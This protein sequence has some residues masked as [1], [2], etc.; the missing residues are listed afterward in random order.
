MKFGLKNTL[1]RALILSAPF[2]LISISVYFLSLW[3]LDVALEGNLYYRLATVSP[4]ITAEK[5]SSVNPYIAYTADDISKISDNNK[6][7]FGD[8]EDVPVISIGDQWATITIESADVHSQPVFHGN[9]D[10]LL[11][12]GIGHYTNSRFPGQHG[13]VILAGHVGIYNHFQRLETMQ[14]GDIVKLDTIYGSYVYRVT[15]TYIMES[16]SEEIR[17]LLL[18]DSEDTGDRLICYTCYPYR[19]TKVRTQRFIIDCELVSGYDFVTGESV[20]SS[21]EN[22]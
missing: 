16:N 17:S 2:L 15:N 9:S 3:T 4:E 1:K 13:K 8:R 11:M 7:A 12:R 22:S 5:N 10:S 6:K 20:G 21:D 19:T 14:A 18:P